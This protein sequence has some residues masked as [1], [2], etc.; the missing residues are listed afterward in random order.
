MHVRIDAVGVVAASGRL[1]SEADGARRLASSLTALGRVDVDTL[2]DRLVEGLRVVGNV[3]A[4]VLELVGLDLD[5]LAA[6]ARAGAR[7][8]DAFEHALMHAAGDGRR[9]RWP[10]R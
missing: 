2:D 8:Y 3:C 9:D 1:E 4:D 10:A 5:V 6:K 7:A